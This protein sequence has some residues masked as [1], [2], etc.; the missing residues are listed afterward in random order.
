MARVGSGQLGRMIGALPGTVTDMRPLLKA[1][2]SSRLS[3]AATSA[4]SSDVAAL[5][6]AGRVRDAL[7]VDSN[8][9]AAGADRIMIDIFRVTR[10]Q[11][12][13]TSG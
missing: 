1:R 5:Y 7:L 2:A 9:D 10:V 3:K 4:V 12:T 6:T 8:S 13:M 11:R